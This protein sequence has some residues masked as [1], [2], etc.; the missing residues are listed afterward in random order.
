M[1]ATK[2]IKPLPTEEKI[3]PQK[4][5][6]NFINN[7]NQSVGQSDVPLEAGPKEFQDIVS[8]LLPADA[9]EE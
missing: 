5:L 9:E 3:I 2:K 6:I 7:Q 1:Q 4:I 8:Q